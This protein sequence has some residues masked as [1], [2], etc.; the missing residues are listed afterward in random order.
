MDEIFLIG[1]GNP[2]KKYSKSRHN[3]GFLLLEN[4][5]KKY[6][7]NF[8]LKDKLKSSCSEFK[9]KNSTYRLF[10]PNTFMNNSG[11]AVRAIVDWYKINLDQI[12]IIVDDKD[13][14]L[15]KIRFRKKGSS[16]GHNG[17]KSIIEK[18]QTHE[19]NRIRIGIGSP[20]SNKEIKNFNTISHVLGNISLEEKLILD[21]V[22]KRVI[23][24]LEQINI[25]K[26]EHIMSELNSFDKDQI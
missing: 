14:P 3:I 16:G 5:S 2:G 7:S 19:F 12:F 9:I 23:E 22:Y 4:L 1:L 13:L 20:P 15:G 6:N 10:L 18:L 26:E 25:K 21:K 17:L 11:D 8:L 24:S